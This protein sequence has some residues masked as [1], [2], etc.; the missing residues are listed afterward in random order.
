MASYPT[1]PQPVFEEVARG[2]RKDESI[3]S[4]ADVLCRR[5]EVTAYKGTIPTMKAESLLP[6]DSQ[7]SRGADGVSPGDELP[8]RDQEFGA[9]TAYECRRYGSQQPLNN[10]DVEQITEH[11]NVDPLEEAL[12][13]CMQDAEV[14]IDARLGSVITDTNLN[15]TFTAGN[16]WSGASGTPLEDIRAAL[17]KVP[18]ADT[19]F[20]GYD[21]V[22]DLISHPDLVA[23]SSNFSAGQLGESQLENLI[24]R[25]FGSIQNVVVGDSYFSNGA[26]EGQTY[27]LSFESSTT[28]WLGYSDDLHL[29]EFTAGEKEGQEQHKTRDAVTVFAQR[30]VDVLRPNDSTG[31]VFQSI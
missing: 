6:R 16:A 31:L 19:I 15:Q 30:Q 11:T 4:L 13:A 29:V 7:S 22:S 1:I 5:R 17:K 24:R 27:S 23:E 26:E 25:K 21:V 8:E 2:L 20:M 3:G 14:Q 28:C 9:D 12:R 10:A 18:G